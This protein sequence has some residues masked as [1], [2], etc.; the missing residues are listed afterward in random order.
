MWS[1]YGIHEIVGHRGSVLNTCGIPE[2]ANFQSNL[3]QH[4]MTVE[5]RLH[6]IFKGAAFYLDIHFI[7]LYATTPHVHGTGYRCP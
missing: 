3:D 7:Q 4:V 6:N 5:Q 2:V 1:R